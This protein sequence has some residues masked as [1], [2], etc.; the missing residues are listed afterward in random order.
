MKWT[1]VLAKLSPFYTSPN[2]PTS[3]FLYSSR[4][5]YGSSV[6]VKRVH[7]PNA[8]VARHAEAEAKIAMEHPHP[9]ITECLGCEKEAAPKGFYVYLFFPVLPKSLYQEIDER[10]ADARY[11]KETE[12]WDFYTQLMDAFVYL[13][14]HNV[15]HRDIKP[16]NILLTEQNQVKLCDFGFAKQMGRQTTAMN[17]LLGTMAYFSPLLRLAYLR[18]GVKQVQHNVF[19]SDVYSLGMVLL[20]L[21]LLSIP[22]KLCELPNL[23]QNLDQQ[24][25][26]L[27]SQYSDRWV[28]LLRCMLRVEED[29]RPDFLEL[30]AQQQS[31]D[32][33]ADDEY[34]E[35]LEGGAE[36]QEAVE[37][38]VKGGLSQVRVSLQET[39]EVPCLVSIAGL[40]PVQDLQGV[41]LVCVL[42]HSSSMSGR[43]LHLIQSILS[44]LAEKIGE[45]DRLALVGCNAQDHR[46]PLTRGTRKGKEWFRENL[47]RFSVLSSTDLVRSFLLAVE[48]LKQRRYPNQEARILIFSDC[49]GTEVMDTSPCLA[50]YRK[51]RLLG[52]KVCGFHYTSKASSCLYKKLVQELNGSLT[53][54]TA[55]EQREE[56]FARAMG[57]NDTTV[58]TDLEV[59]ITPQTSKVP[60]EVT[61]VYS[62]TASSPVSFPLLQ[63]GQTHS[64]VFLL[65]PKAKELTAP[66]RCSAAEVTLNYTDSEGTRCV[67]S[68][69]FDVKFVKWSSAP[70]AKDAL[71]HAEWQ[72]ARR[73]FSSVRC[74]LKADVLLERCIARLQVYSSGLDIDDVVDDLQKARELVQQHPSWSQGDNL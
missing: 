3:V 71:V 36:T 19:K 17:S 70:G 22:N 23:Q 46:A 63:M 14:Q 45:R 48:V 29:I 39:D 20:Q 1:E 33:I 51:S 59:L 62:E 43:T 7:C 21:T 55:P 72:K 66:V 47:P 50:A 52:V 64:L 32:F 53:A 49:N 57:R 28:E 6:V 74:L 35:V 26:E 68:V 41:D 4:S 69:Q 67:K 40:A 24:F 37:L 38:T 18:G 10:A 34:L 61:Q 2:E 54:V 13:Q 56:M 31:A 42:D 5:V 25:R 12:L 58:A 9:H 27:K 30:Q 11:Y 60:C 73:D 15:A 44:G 65:R 8:E 16:Q